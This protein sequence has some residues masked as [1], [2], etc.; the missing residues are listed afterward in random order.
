LDIKNVQAIVCY[1]R[2]IQPFLLNKYK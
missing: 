2:S 1:L